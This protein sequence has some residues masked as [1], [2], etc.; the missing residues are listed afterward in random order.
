M[1]TSSRRVWAVRGNPGQSG[2]IRGNPGP[3][4]QNPGQSGAIGA[5]RVNRG[6]HLI[7]ASVVVGLAARAGGIHLVRAEAKAAV[8]CGAEGGGA[9]GGGGGGG[10]Q[11]GRRL[12]GGG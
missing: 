3:S 1:R 12:G 10:E 9:Q 6:N 2:A 5:I 8:A 4:G 7:K 11:R